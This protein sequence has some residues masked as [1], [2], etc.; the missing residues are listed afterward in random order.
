MTKPASKSSKPVAALPP[1]YAPLLS[2]I[3]ARV[4]AARIKAGLAANREL[5]KL[6]WDIGRLILDRQQKE[7]WGAKVIDRLS[8]DLQNE[9][10]GQQG[11]SPRNLKY[12]RTFAEAWPDEQI[13]QAPLAQITWYHNIAL[14][15]KLTNAEQRL[16]Y[17]RKAIENG[18]IG[19]ND[20][21]IRIIG[22]IADCAD[23]AAQDR[24]VGR[25]IALTARRFRP[26]KTAV[27]RG[28]RRHREGDGPVGPG[29]GLVGSGGD[30]DFVARLRRRQSRLQVR[31]GVGPGRAGVRATQG[32]SCTGI[33]CP[34]DMAGWPPR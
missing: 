33:P 21:V 26:G 23:V 14:I 10:P 4:Q 30:P 25:P 17:A 28:V 8:A 15:E 13:V 3:K 19:A 11:F 22:G 24:R 18:G 20:D 2:E 9:F 16:R 12:M 1:D 29:G 7:G 34:C 6:Y 32:G 5:L 27:D 31:V